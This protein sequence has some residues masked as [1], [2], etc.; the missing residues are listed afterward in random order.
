MN[1]AILEFFG[2]PVQRRRNVKWLETVRVQR[3]PYLDRKCLKTRKS[4]AHIAIGT[5]SLSYGKDRKGVVIC[6]HRLLERKQIFTDCLHLL[7]RHEPGNELHLVGEISIPGG[8][9]DYVLASLKRGKVVDFVGIELQTLD[10]TGTVWPERQRLLKQL[11]LAVR[12][13]DVSSSKGF[14]M[15]W[16]MT[17]K[18]TLVQLHHK[19]S[20][21][22]AV[23]RHLVLVLQ[24]HLMSYMEHQ[25]SFGHISSA[26]LGD[27]MHFHSYELR[28]EGERFRIVLAR[29]LSTDTEGIAASLGLKADSN[30]S[31]KKLINVI[32]AKISERTRL[33]F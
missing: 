17:A 21:F 5:C 29:R 18:T 13:Q 27:P 31:L 12:A 4:Q 32:Q 33:R 8:S 3:C 2:V 14:G 11:G 6:P 10:T 28:T 30:V 7:T 1:T 20:T 25:F 24:D 9:V 15:N 22:E 19:V 23:N 26:R 16:K